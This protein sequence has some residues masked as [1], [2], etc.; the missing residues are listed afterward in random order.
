MENTFR[1]I[2]IGGSSGAHAALA[3]LLKDIPTGINAAFLVVLH[4][5][6]IPE[7]NFASALGKNIKLNVKEAVSSQTI[8]KGNVYLSLPNMHLNISD[9]KIVLSM[10]PR[11]NLFRPSIDVLFRSAAVNFGNRCIGV[12]LSGRLSDGTAGLDAIKRCGGKSIVQDPKNAEFPDMPTSA[13]EAIEVDYCLP[14]DRISLQIEK[15]CT[16]P[17]TTKTQIPASLRRE[18]EIALKIQ[19]QVATEDCL[20][21]QVAFS[22]PGCG[23]P[24]WK[25]KDGKMNRYRCHVGH[26]FS[27][28]AM[29][30]GQN[31]KVEEALWI[32][33]RT[34]EE[35]RNLLMQM[36]KNYSGKKINKLTNYYEDKMSEVSKH[37]ELLRSAMKIND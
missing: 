22:C 28:E 25:M 29:L 32:A 17:L 20:G 6:F 19:S 27:R 13:L 37:I 16:Q 2:V 3:K 7:L 5:S 14:I 12:L 30:A 35:K 21:E 26:A 36:K 33:L 9:G 8:E 24:L 34:L 11:E 31:E 18:A 15:I 10:G 1:I 23:G 4:G